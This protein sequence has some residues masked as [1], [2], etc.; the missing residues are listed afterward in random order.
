MS[1]LTAQTGTPHKAQPFG[2]RTILSAI[3]CLVCALILVL[4]VSV[5]AAD[6]QVSAQGT[7]GETTAP[8]AV[9]LPDPLTQDAIDA[10]VARL[11]DSDVRQLLL[12]QLGRAAVPAG[13]DAAPLDV[14]GLIA[15]LVSSW[16][17]AIG[18]IAS[19][20]GA[21][22]AV[23]AS[24]VD[25]RAG[26]AVFGVLGLIAGSLV[27]GLIAEFGYNRLVSRARSYVREH[28]PE[29]LWPRVTILALRCL[30]ELL[31][32]AV[33][34]LVAFLAARALLPVEN[35]RFV[36]YT[37]LGIVAV[38]RVFRAFA[39][40]IF[41]PSRPDLRLVMASDKGAAYMVRQFTLI[42]I[43]GPAASY[44][45]ALTWRFGLPP[46]EFKIGF[47]LNL[48]LHLTVI[49]TIWKS[50]AGLPRLFGA[51][52]PDMPGYARRLA[53]AWPYV[54]IGLVVFIWLLI[55]I[56]VITGNLRLLGPHTIYVTLAIVLFMPIFDTMARALV[57]DAYPAIQ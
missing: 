29:G 26:G 48:A 56:I 25:G 53:M 1:T 16:G 45:I 55:E 19:Y 9:A 21:F 50:R 12:D 8:D 18:K 36:L 14:G 42:G 11:S 46:G 51:D 13:E 20:P 17:G 35:D 28:Q 4:A 38:A 15:G 41:A 39:L 43:L 40:F 34:A 27:I 52:D 5:G 57:R 47:W 33:F 32:I 37:I 2:R 49:W 22:A 7:A 23:W 3:A 10:L 44:I 30:L 31:G 6:A 24:F 54:S